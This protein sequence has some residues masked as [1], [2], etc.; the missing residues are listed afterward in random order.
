MNELKVKCDIKL[1]HQDTSKCDLVKIL[2]QIFFKYQFLVGKQKSTL[3]NVFI[4][5][6]F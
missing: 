4:D 6:K 1:Y 5:L 3:L 2:T